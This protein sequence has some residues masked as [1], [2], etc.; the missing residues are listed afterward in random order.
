PKE[1]ARR[2]SS[3][4]ARFR[5]PSSGRAAISV[6]SRRPRALD[7]PPGACSNVPGSTYDPSASL[8]EGPAGA[9][10]HLPA[11]LLLRGLGVV[12]ALGGRPPLKAGQLRAVLV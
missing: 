7:L 12:P 9:A 5:C 10:Y 2:L 1:N 3:A 6:G 8:L 4:G 11:G